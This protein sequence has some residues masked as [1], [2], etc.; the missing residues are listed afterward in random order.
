MQ[1]VYPYP[2]PIPKEDLEDLVT[3]VGELQSLITQL[4][5]QVTTLQSS[6]SSVQSDIS[7]LNA[8]K[9]DKYVPS[10]TTRAVSSSNSTTNGGAQTWYSVTPPSVSGYTFCGVDRIYIEA[11]GSNTLTAY[12]WGFNGSVVQ[13]AVKNYG[14]SSVTAKINVICRYIKNT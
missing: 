4:Q 8:M 12:T 5:S 2:L 11:T 6:M 9:H 13:V 1:T 10:F 3:N 14:S 7:S